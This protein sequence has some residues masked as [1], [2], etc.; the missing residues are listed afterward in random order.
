MPAQTSLLLADNP[1]L[2]GNR[3]PQTLKFGVGAGYDHIFDLSW[4]GTVKASI[5]SRFKSNYYRDFF[6][7][8]DPRQAAFKQT[9]LTLEYRPENKKFTV[10]AFIRNL[11]NTRP[12]A[13]SGFAAAGSGRIF[14]WQF[15]APRTYGERVSVD[16]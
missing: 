16:F 6:N 1:N 14:N 3:L 4:A 15:G 10:Q 2:A 12:L 8:R 9:D 13:Y 11:E 7:F 5:F